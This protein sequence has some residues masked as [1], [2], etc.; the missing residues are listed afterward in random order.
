[1]QNSIQ[2]GRINELLR[3]FYCSDNSTLNEQNT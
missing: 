1:M 3:K 2:I